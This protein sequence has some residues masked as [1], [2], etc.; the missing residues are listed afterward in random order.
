MCTIESKLVFVMVFIITQ[1]SFWTFN[2]VDVPSGASHNKEWLTWTRSWVRR[3]SVRDGSPARSLAVQATWSLR[4]H[5]NCPTSLASWFGLIPIVVGFSSRACYLKFFWTSKTS[6]QFFWVVTCSAPISYMS[7]AA[8]QETTHSSPYE[9]WIAMHLVAWWKSSKRTSLH[10]VILVFTSLNS[11]SYKETN[12]R[13]FRIVTMQWVRFSWSIMTSSWCL[14]F[15]Y[16]KM[17]SQDQSISKK[18][19]QVLKD[20]H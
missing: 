1:C 6:Y 20:N 16:T 11:H 15:N 18:C 4:H 10:V 2:R 3:H 17:Y 19:T 14:C 5:A 8:S 13:T 9:R 7:D 12:T